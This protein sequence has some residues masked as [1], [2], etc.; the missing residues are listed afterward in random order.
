MNTFIKTLSV[1]AILV[2]FGSC[3]S[4]LPD[5]PDDTN[6]VVPAITTFKFASSD[7]DCGAYTQ[8]RTGAMIHINTEKC[9][10]EVYRPTLT[11]HFSSES[12]LT[13]GTLTVGSASSPK[14]GEIYIYASDYMNPNLQPQ[15]LWVGIEGSIKLTVNKDDPSL[16]N[17]QFKS[18]KMENTSFSVTTGLPQFDTLTGY[19]I[20]I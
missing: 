13:E 18:I 4:D 11:L 7:I 6:T 3:N 20:G 1:L 14:A 2:A 17:V 19:I 16:L 8:Q 15:V 5:N 12:A 9:N 10:G